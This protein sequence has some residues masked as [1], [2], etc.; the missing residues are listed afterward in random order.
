MDGYS[1]LVAFFKVV[2]PLMA[3]A[4]L[5][6]LFL[7]SRDRTP[8]ATIPFADAEIKERLRDQ[9][10][11]GPFFSGAT[12]D[13]DSISL[14]AEEVLTSGGRVGE[15]RAE[16]ISARIDTHGGTRITLL[17]DRGEISLE[18]DRST[19]EGNVAVTTSTG[20]SLKSDRVNARLDLLD[21]HSPGPAVGTAPFGTV[22][23]GS[24]RLSRRAD[25][26][27]AHLVFTN[28]VKLVYRP[29]D[30]EK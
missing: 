25:S 10:I 21:L 27:S 26:D 9:Q 5:S 3:L 28:R 13:G 14:A 15:N 12:R 2:L 16:A 1:R 8:D 4:I 29:R 23:A 30:I 20:F 18:Q 22:H 17:A 19:L 24:M 11:T 6:T 7:L